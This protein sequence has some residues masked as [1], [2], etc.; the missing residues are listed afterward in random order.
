MTGVQTCAL[1][2]CNM[3]PATAIPMCVGA[4]LLSKGEVSNKGILVTEEAIDNPRQ[5]LDE[6]LERVHAL[7]F[8]E[9]VSEQV[10]FRTN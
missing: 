3:A 4:E 10:T 8:I 5:F 2:I 6:V 1:P 9:E 7:G